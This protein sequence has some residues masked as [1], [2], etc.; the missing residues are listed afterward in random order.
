MHFGSAEE[1]V[2]RGAAK[3]ANKICTCTT[4]LRNACVKV[5]KNCTARASSAC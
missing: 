3:G 4:I 1:F 2:V 5:R